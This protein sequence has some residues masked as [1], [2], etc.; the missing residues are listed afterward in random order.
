MQLYVIDWLFQNAEDQL[1]ATNQFID[2]LKEGKL[3]QFVE[4]FELNYML[5]TP[6][7]GSGIII[8]K[9]NNPKTLYNLIKMWRESYCIKFD[10]KPALTNEELLEIH[11]SK[12][13]W[14][15]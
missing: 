10:V 11:S 8:C 12:E 5:H 13:F 4:G 14:S 3:N 9:A 7:N 2:Y 15:E 1:F 6:Q